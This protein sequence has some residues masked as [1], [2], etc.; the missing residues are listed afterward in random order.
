[1]IAKDVLGPVTSMQ[2]AHAFSRKQNKRLRVTVR[3]RQVS[4]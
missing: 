1:M 4:D 2:H 3:Q